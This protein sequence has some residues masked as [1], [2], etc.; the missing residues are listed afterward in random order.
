MASGAAIWEASDKVIDAGPPHRSHML[1]ADVDDIE[2]INDH[3]RGGRFTITGTD[4]AIGIMELADELR[5]GAIA[6]AARCAA[7]RST[8]SMSSSRRPRPIRMAAMSARSRSTRRPATTQ[9][10]QYKMVN[11]FGV[12]INPLMVEGQAHGGIVQ[13]IGQALSEATAYDA[14]GQLLTGSFMDYALPRAG[15]APS[16]TF[17]SHP[18]PARTNLLGAKGCGEAG[19]A[20]SLP[21]VMNAVVD[22]LAELRHH[23]YRHARDAAARVAGHPAG[24]AQGGVNRAALHPLR[25]KQWME[26]RPWAPQRNGAI[27]ICGRR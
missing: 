17:E 11:D 16:F 13:G 19:C 25:G 24:A 7:T 3:R 4:R 27:P 12:L 10:V 8:C 9:V 18:V 23:A 21:A 2:F 22:A 1:E 20:G 15:D 26:R 14:D 5:A 6:T